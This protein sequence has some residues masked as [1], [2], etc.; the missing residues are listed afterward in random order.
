MFQI[1]QGDI[2][3]MDIEGNTVGRVT[4]QPGVTI[5]DLSWNCERFNMEEQPEQS[6]QPEQPQQPTASTSSKPPQ[7]CLRS[8]GKLNI[9]R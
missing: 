4:L 8:D 3:A 7:Q 2:L 1:F 9:F 5:T 6:R